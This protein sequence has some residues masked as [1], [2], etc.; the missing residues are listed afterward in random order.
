[1]AWFSTSPDQCLCTTLQNWQH[2]NYIFSLQ[3]G[4]LF[5]WQKHKQHT[6][7]VLLKDKM[8]FATLIAADI[9]WDTVVKYLTD[10]VRWLRISRKV[11]R[12][13]L[14]ARYHGRH[15][16]RRLC[17]YQ[18]AGCF[19]PCVGLVWCIQFIFLR[20]Y[21]VTVCLLVTCGQYGQIDS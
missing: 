17:A 8:S 12:N 9:C 11:C 4:V 19:V 21:T 16:E 20:V 2:G 3:Y 15:G 18:M 14:G 7:H 10:S 5:C 6:K 1:M 13:W